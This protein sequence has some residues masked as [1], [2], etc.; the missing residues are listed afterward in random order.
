MSM[1]K[2][3]AL[4]FVLSFGMHVEI[5]A[6]WNSSFSFDG[7]VKS[8]RFD[9]KVGLFGDSKLVSN[10]SSIQM[11]DSV[12]GSEG[13]VFYKKPIKLFKGK[14]RNSV[15]FSSYFSFSMPN[16]IGDVLGFVM[17][18][19]SLDLSLFSK[20]DKSSSALGFL[21]EYVKNETVVAFEFGISSLG[22]NARILV[23]RPE[24]AKIRNLSFVGDLMMRSGGRL[25][26]MIEYEA[27]SKRMMVRFRKSGSVKL[28]DPFFAFSVDLGKLWK[29]GE[30][31]VGLSSANG[32]S[33]N[34]HFLHSWRFE[35]R[36]PPPVWMHSEPL[37]P[38]EVSVEEK[39]SRGGSEYKWR[40]V[41]ALL[42]G[43]VC[44]T[45]GT[46]FALYLWTICSVR[47]SVAV[48]PEECAVKTAA[49]NVVVVIEE[50]KKY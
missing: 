45:L 22:N 25:N 3:V 34:A 12:S 21:L 39:E 35:I 11:T 47:R 14:Q 13:R 4:L 9:K 44:G 33:S 49:S 40:M 1:F 17:V 41:G 15:S 29:G 10:S 18:P 20:K 5:A 6:G 27:S 26:C 23:G 42:L 8:N 31:M 28:F 50:G 32:N 24:S 48:V 37:E 7:F 36:H 19:S 38:T 43:V 30:V 2:I 46:M 16:E